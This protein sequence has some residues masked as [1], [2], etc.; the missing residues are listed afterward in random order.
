MSV[1]NPV[2]VRERLTADTIPLIAVDTSRALIDAFA[3]C[4]VARADYADLAARKD[5]REEAW[6][7]PGWDEIV[8]YTG[9]YM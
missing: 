7:K 8:A 9:A 6:R 1:L 2:A 4:L 3:F 5:V